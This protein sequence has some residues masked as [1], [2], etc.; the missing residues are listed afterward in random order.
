MAFQS[1]SALSRLI[2]STPNPLQSPTSIG[3]LRYNSSAAS[4]SA[5][6][7]RDVILGD[8]I[9]DHVYSPSI[10]HSDGPVTQVLLGSYFVN[11]LILYSE[12]NNKIDL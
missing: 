3:Y 9:L 10:S 1:L 12:A 11:G 5:T 4:E 7:Y 8:E 6:V 2:S